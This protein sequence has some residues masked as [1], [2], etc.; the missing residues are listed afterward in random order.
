[1]LTLGL[2]LTGWGLRHLFDPPR[3]SEVGYVRVFGG[4]PYYSYWQFGIFFLGLLFLLRG[5]GIIKRLS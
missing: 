2:A 1:M 3:L 4:A 5:I